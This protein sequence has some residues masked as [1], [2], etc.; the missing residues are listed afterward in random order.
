MT[1]IDRADRER[2]ERAG[3]GAPRRA[4]LVGVEPELLADEHVERGLR[5]REDAVRDPRRLVRR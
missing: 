5:V 3:G 2:D 1:G 4:E